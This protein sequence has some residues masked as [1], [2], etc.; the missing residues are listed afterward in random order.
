MNYMK[1]NV[2]R[3][4]IPYKLTD[5][6]TASETVIVTFF[7][8][9]GVQTEKRN[10]G[11]LSK[12]ELIALK[13]KYPAFRLKELYFRD[14]SIHDYHDLFEWD[15]SKILLSINMEKCFF[16]GKSDFSNTDF[17]KAGFSLANSFFGNDQVN[18]QKST[19]LSDIVNF[20]GI[21]FGSGEKNFSYTNFY[22]KEIQ[23]FSTNFSDGQVSFRASSF[24]NAHLNVG[25]AIFG[26]GDVDFEF[27]VFGAGGVDF[28]GVN[29]GD[30]EVSFQNGIFNS[31]DIFFFG[32]T[33]GT[34]KISFS[35][36]VI[37]DGNINFSFCVY[38][39]C[40]IHLRYVKFGFCIIN[41]SSMNLAEGYIL[42][43]SVEFKSKGMD[44]SESAINQII[45]RDSLFFEHVNMSLKKCKT[46]TI[47]NCIIEKTINL[48]SSSKRTVNIDCLNL[49]N[50]RNLGQI[51]LDWVMN[52]VKKMIYAQGKTT[53]YQE[54]A[55]Q[56]RLLKEN[57]R[58]IGQYDD[59]DFAYVE[60]KR[61]MSIS[62]LK[63]EDLLHHKHKRLKRIRR[64]IAF[65]FKWLILDF[66]GNYAT[67]PFRIIE[68][69][70]LTV[71]AFAALYTMPFIQLHG[72]KTL[73]D[74]TDSPTLQLYGKALY[75]SIA[76]IFTIG[77]GDVNPSNIYAML[78]SGFEGF[79]G[80]FLM[81]YFTVAFVRKILR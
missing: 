81:S 32:S 62:E 35:G 51:Y 3:Q 44:F 63:G 52:D 41:M 53:D 34:G 8:D 9:E 58:K 19:F 6:L 65:P 46:L 47:E 54:K 61:C 49:L 67:N 2:V 73:I 15:D 55:N 26:I 39:N 48:S 69:M 42:F 43:K 71:I 16:D 70:L 60:Y 11:Y 29:F 38:A 28:S 75:H 72:E 77:Y 56:L 68:T 20:S 18:F 10:F 50:T 33:F 37:G 76:T 21:Q 5:C 40:V 14:F 64:Y 1:Y 7:S 80:L 25:G 17:G 31:G 27:C 13:L 30:G 45:F 59:E 12:D 24:V 78:L 23:F 36:A 57:F 66:V 22:G 4:A 79:T 74:S